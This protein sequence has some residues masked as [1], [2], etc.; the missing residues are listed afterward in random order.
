MDVARGVDLDKPGNVR[1]AD[2]HL[3][4]GRCRIERG[5]PRDIGNCD[6]AAGHP[7][8]VA[9]RN[10]G[11]CDGVDCGQVKGRSGIERDEGDRLRSDVDRAA[12]SRIAEVGGTRRVDGDIAAGYD[13]GGTRCE[14]GDR[15]GEVSGR[16]GMTDACGAA[17]DIDIAAVTLV[18]E[19]AAV[20]I[21]RAHGHRAIRGKIDI[22]ARV[23]LGDV[24]IGRSRDR[25][26]VPCREGAGRGNASPR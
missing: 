3:S 26:V 25:D 12:R 15:G 2:C 4:T 1:L 8:G 13:R 6:A 9:G 14:A 18:V 10:G 22:V 7:D 23:E 19:A 17:D 16:F 21:G 20:G 5:V 24:D 11:T